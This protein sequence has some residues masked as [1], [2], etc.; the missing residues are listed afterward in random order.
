MKT[1]PLNFIKQN[2]KYIIGF[3]SAFVGSYAVGAATSTIMENLEYSKEVIALTTLVTRTASYFVINLPVHHFLHREEYQN[4][5]R[6]A[7]HEMKTIGTSNIIGATT[8]AVLQP[9]FHWSAMEMGINNP[10]SFL[11]AYLAAGAISTGV[12][13]VI[14]FKNKVIVNKNLER[15]IDEDKV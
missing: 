8:N 9:S 3:G 14:D 10:Y 5:E 12:K 6:N 4:K 1:N 13:F 11:M 2:R 15:I 7:K